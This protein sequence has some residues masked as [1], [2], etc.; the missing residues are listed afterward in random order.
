MASMAATA[1]GAATVAAET[2]FFFSPSPALPGPPAPLATAVRLTVLDGP[3]RLA[4][5]MDVVVALLGIVSLGLI[6][7]WV[8]GGGATVALRL[9]VGREAVA[10]LEGALAVAGAAAGGAARR[11]R[12]RGTRRGAT[13]PPP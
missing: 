11:G 10:G 5:S 2:P 3:G 9:A 1:S 13:V 6:G 4:P 8:G 7:C 12:G